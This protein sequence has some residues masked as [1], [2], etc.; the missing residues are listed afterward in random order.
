M[1][2]RWARA[3]GARAQRACLFAAIEAFEPSGAGDSIRLEIRSGSRPNRQLE[4]GGKLPWPEKTT[5]TS[6][7]E[8]ERLQAGWVAVAGLEPATY[9]L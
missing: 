5:W 6:S 9:G 3:Q 4:S 7:S 2:A 8:T 1:R